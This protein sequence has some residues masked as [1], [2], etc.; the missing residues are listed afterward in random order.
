VRAACAAL[1][2]AAC[3]PATELIV[4]VDTTFGVPCTID[5]LQIEATGGGATR[6]VEVALTGADLPGSIAVATDGEARDATITVTGL[7]GGEPFALARDTVKFDDDSALELRFVLDRSCVPGPCPSVG[8]GGFTGLPPPVERRG[9]GDEAYARTADPQFVIRDACDMDAEVSGVVLA[10]DPDADER[11]VPSPLSPAVPFPFRFY[12][13]RVEQLWVGSNGYVGFGAEPPHALQGDVGAPRSLGEPGGFP[14]RGV[15]A[16]W[17]NLRLGARGICFAMSGEAPE[18][19]LWITWKEACFSAGPT[20]CGAPAQGTLT[21]SVGLE[22]TTDR[23]YVGYGTMVAAGAVD[24]R[25]K[26]NAATIGITN[27]AERGCPASACQPDGTCGDGR[28]CGYTEISAQRR[29][30]LSVVE[31]VPR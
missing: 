18:R 7:R 17:D 28:P 25:A 26:G 12:G 6:S 21:F 8:A 4:T 22:E 30:A 3:A 11:E 13:E 16:F 2:L 9:C 29:A 15:L 1:L 31:L 10:G 27:A 19:L 5:G 23:V 14:G 24:D 20:L